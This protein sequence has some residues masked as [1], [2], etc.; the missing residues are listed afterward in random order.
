MDEFTPEQAA[1]W[2]AWQHANVLSTRR[3]DRIA[4]LVGVTLLAATLTAVAV[5]IWR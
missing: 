1:R 3:S 4:R 5:A 2:D